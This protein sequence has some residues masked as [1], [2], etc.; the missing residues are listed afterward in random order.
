MIDVLVTITMAF[1]PACG[2]NAHDVFGCQQADATI[3]RAN[4]N[5]AT[6]G[7]YIERRTESGRV[8]VRVDYPIAPRY[9]KG[10]N[11]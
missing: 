11:Q 1:L 7:Y 6:T 10:A 4:F 8:T 5:V 9:L 3:T 2:P